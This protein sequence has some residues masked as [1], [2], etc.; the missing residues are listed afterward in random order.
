MRADREKKTIR[1]LQAE[2]AK[3]EKDYEELKRGAQD[4]DKQRLDLVF[5]NRRLQE[6]VLDQTKEIA[7]LKADLQ[8]VREKNTALVS[9]LTQ[10]LHEAVFL[11]ERCS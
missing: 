3:L 1:T 7:A 4:L 11:M 6:S 5:N 2:I 9:L 10:A 8:S